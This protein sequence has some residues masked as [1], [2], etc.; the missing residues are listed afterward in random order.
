MDAALIFAFPIDSI[1][2]SFLFMKLPPSSLL[3][4]CRFQLCSNQDSSVYQPQPPFPSIS[5]HHSILLG[6]VIRLLS[7]I[8]CPKANQ[9][10]G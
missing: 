2:F 3:K 1:K 7:L 5:P 8:K 6:L 4:S 9:E 10:G